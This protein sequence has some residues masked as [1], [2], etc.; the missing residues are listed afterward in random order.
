M[1]VPL[2]GTLWEILYNS[3]LQWSHKIE[4]IEFIE[5]K[6]EVT[7]RNT[8]NSLKRETFKDNK[9][10]EEDFSEEEFGE[11]IDETS[12][13]DL[14]NIKINIDTPISNLFKELDDQNKL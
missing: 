10:N 4:F 13:I 14:N 9:L 6:K 7:K 3:N 5:L 2:N 8:S 11:V 1:K 12:F